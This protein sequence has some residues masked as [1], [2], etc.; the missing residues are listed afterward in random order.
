MRQCT[1]PPMEFAAFVLATM[2]AS[3]ESNC[4]SICNNPLHMTVAKDHCI[5]SRIT[6]KLPIVTRKGSLHDATWRSCLY[7]S[8]L[9]MPRT[10]DIQAMFVQRGGP[11]HR[12]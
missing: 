3:T 2:Q 5:F 8:L 9:H 7:G 4:G 1:V 6:L 10:V 12:S 11:G